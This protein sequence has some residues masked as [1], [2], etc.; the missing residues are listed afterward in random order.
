MTRQGGVTAGPEARAVARYG[1]TQDAFSAGWLLPDGTMIEMRRRRERRFVEHLHVA[2]F[3]FTAAE[4]P[5]RWSLARPDPALRAALEAG[6]ICVIQDLHRGLEFE[7]ITP[8]T[9]AQRQ[10]I[11]AAAKLATTLAVAVPDPAMGWE[12]RY[13]S[14][15]QPSSP[16]MASRLLRAAQATM[17]VVNAPARSSPA[18][19]GRP[20]PGPSAQRGRGRRP[21][22]GPAL[23]LP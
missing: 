17:T 6:W 20:S 7:L 13:W 5:Y 23:L 16:L 9:P 19:P 1:T 3:S 8:P 22:G 14:G 4:R 12:A 2:A 11:L 21:R 15:L 18:A 10:E